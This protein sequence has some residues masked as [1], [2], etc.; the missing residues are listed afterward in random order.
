MVARNETVCVAK[1]TLT[2]IIV[3][4]VGLL[5]VL[6]ISKNISS[7]KI[8]TQ[9]RAA[10]APIISGYP[11][12]ANEKSP[13]VYL[14]GSEGPLAENSNIIETN[15]CSG[16]LIHPQWFLTAYHCLQDLKSIDI[17][18]TN[19][20]GTME[21]VYLHNIFTYQKPITAS[22]NTRFVADIALIRL[23]Q[24]VTNSY[25]FPY[26]PTYEGENYLYDAGNIVT[27]YGYGVSQ[28]APTVTPS[29]HRTVWDRFGFPSATPILPARMPIDHKLYKTQLRIFSVDR[30]S[31]KFSI[32][33]I[34]ENK[35][36]NIEVGDSGGPDFI[37]DSSGNLFLLGIHMEAYYINE[38]GKKI[39]ISEESVN[40]SD[41]THWI[42]DTMYSFKDKPKM[43]GF[44]KKCFS[45][46]TNADNCLEDRCYLNHRCYTKDCV[47]GDKPNHCVS[48][49][50]EKSN[51]TMSSSWQE[52][53]LQNCQPSN[54]ILK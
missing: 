33:Y 50:V 31:G 24:T 5:G 53:G 40:V 29:E 38:V 18:V 46:N 51:D 26:L 48:C 37:R 21:K 7:R 54:K 12:D 10:P 9:N 20:D 43:L 25:E 35:P 52:V 45:Y 49:T 6:L 36:T 16:V 28:Y 11:V 8:V 42:V 13:V 47:I 27:S 34:D 30:V 39:M 23:D 4:M 14:H 41:F 17:Y 32:G 1:N 22:D 3:S 19:K 15:N 44:D 2:V